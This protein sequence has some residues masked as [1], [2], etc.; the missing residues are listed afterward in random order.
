MRADKIF[1]QELYDETRRL[2]EK[3]DWDTQA[4]KSN[5]YQFAWE[6][7]CGKK[8]LEEAKKQFVTDDWHLAK[9][10][11]TWFRRNKQIEWLPLEKIKPY[12]LKCIQN[13]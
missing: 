12:V 5:I 6:Y 3:Y 1:V 9:R 13:E 4:M 8:S 7:M 11:I 2:V 10:Q